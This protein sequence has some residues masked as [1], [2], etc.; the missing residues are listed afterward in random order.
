MNTTQ[1]GALTLCSDI[2]VELKLELDAEHLNALSAS[3]ALAGVPAQDREQFSTYFDT[4]N[5]NLRAEGFSLRVRRTGRRHVQTIKTNASA[6]AGM[7][8]RSEWEQDVVAPEPELGIASPLRTL[9]TDEVL[10]QVA[11][12]FTVA[13]TRRQWLIEQDG[14]VIELVADKGI[15]TAADRSTS[16]SEIELELKRGPANAVFRLARE[17]ARDVPI[18][19]GVLTK[20]ERGYRLIEAAGTDAVKAERLALKPGA[21]AAAAFA[22]IVGVCLRQF[23]LNEDI[24]R[25]DPNPGALHQARVALRR[26]RSALSIFK[27]INT[28]DRLEHLAGEL[29]WLAGSLGDARDLDVLLER[30]GHETAGGLVAAR[31]D[32]YAAA[33]GALDSQR[34]RDLMVDLVEWSVLGDWRTRPDNQEIVNRR[35]DLFAAHTLCKLRRRIKRRGRE[36]AELDDED[37]HRVRILAKK[38]RYAAGF[39]EMLYT[40]KKAR[41]RF[42]AFLKSMEALQDRLGELNDLATAPNLLARFGL[43]TNVAMPAGRREALLAHAAEAHQALMDAKRF[44]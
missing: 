37:R 44:W 21:T 15:V 32:A 24:L 12:A 11:P 20:A 2:E 19:V 4:P 29:R 33:L 27:P 8:A 26:L 28:D 35:A 10:G 1:T 16:V 9:M 36:L 42:K 13:V 22:G 34:A 3:H 6:A 25:R 5:Q 30:L 18:R 23:R 31:G 41:L 14:A 40:G 39:F 43:D 17:L 38:L 7:F